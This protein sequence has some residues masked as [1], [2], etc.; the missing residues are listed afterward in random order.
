M[1]DKQSARGEI[2]S[3]R[4]QLREHD[5]RYYVLA[6]PVIADKEYDELLKR[7]QKLEQDFPEFR[8]P[9][10][11]TVRLSGGI[12]AGFLSVRH[13]V[14]M[15]SLDNTYSSDELY[16]WQ[17]RVRKS[18]GAQQ[19]L[20]FVAELK[21]DGVSASLSYEDGVLASAST[22]GDGETGED[23]T[24]NIKTIRAVPLLLRG[25]SVPSRV[26]V[27]GEVYM[28]KRD[29][30]S[31]NKVKQEAAE[32]LFANPR[33]AAAGS[34]KLLDSAEVASRRLSFFAHSV[35]ECRGEKI[36][37]QWQLFER[38]RELGI[39]CNPY[40]EL[41]PGIDEVLKFCAHWQEKR[42]SLP[43]EI[44]GVVVKVNQL[45]AQE[46]LGAT[47]KSPRWAV[48]Y[49][50]PARQATTD[51]L[52]INFNVGRTGIV[53]PTAELSA[54]ECGGVVIRNA[55][56]HNFEEI[57]RLNLREGDRVLIERAG[58]VIPKIVKVVEQ[59]GI[60][61]FSVPQACPACG[62]KLFKEKEQDVAL[63]CLNSSCPAQLERGLLHFASRAAMDISGMGEAVVAQLVKLGLVRD[64][65]DIYSLSADTR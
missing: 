56:L 47:S 21:I 30:A 44:D 1:K 57:K 65:A 51:V 49:K 5:Y 11:P 19:R 2:D 54:V 53:T 4:S 17:E 14:K 32:V 22:R 33:N 16:A 50:F 35:G 6:Q 58:D 3:L 15:L 46:K 60:K 63:R 29:F 55:T 40:A 20:E 26:D 28:D 8:S 42:D 27:R 39:R 64:F 37:S 13:S 61:L 24:L 25:K 9:D 10:S 34:L 41:C 36:I 31:L 38:F 59:K 12:S 48:A 7:L 62:E 45:S 43:Y 52:K 23:I 18:L